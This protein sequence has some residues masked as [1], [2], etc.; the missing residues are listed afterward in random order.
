VRYFMSVVVAVG[1]ARAAEAQI[2]LSV[3]ALEGQAVNGVALQS[4][5]V[6]ALSGTGTVVFNSLAATQTFA[7]GGGAFQSFANTR[8]YA[9]LPAQQL[10]FSPRLL[11]SDTAML[12]GGGS[13]GGGP[14][15]VGDVFVGPASAPVRLAEQSGLVPDR[16]DLH[17]L[18]STGFGLT[19]PTMGRSGRIVFGGRTNGP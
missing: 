8:T 12:A 10:L 3:R 19:Y 17:C 14:T 16:P 1:C 6:P 4:I 13:V 11:I 15:N 2:V 5:Q 18:G 7:F 9:N